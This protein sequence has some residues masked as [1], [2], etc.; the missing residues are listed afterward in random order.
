[1]NSS[2]NILKKSPNYSIPINK[3]RLF[4]GLFTFF[5]QRRSS[6]P[7]RQQIILPDKVVE[8]EGRL[9]SVVHSQ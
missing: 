8:V 4:A 9:I 2:A 5:S 6:I 7:P 1:M 3:K